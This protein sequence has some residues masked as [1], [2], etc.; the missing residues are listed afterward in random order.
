MLDSL[1][2]SFILPESNEK[3]YEYPVINAKPYKAA[4][5]TDSAY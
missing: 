3:L 1:V 4:E 2:K 5:S